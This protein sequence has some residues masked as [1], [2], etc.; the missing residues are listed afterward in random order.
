MMV[1]FTGR[2]D[3]QAY[4]N[5]MHRIAWITAACLIDRHR[6]RAVDV[7]REHLSDV[8]RA[9]ALGEPSE[10]LEFWCATARALI[11]ILRTTREVGEAAH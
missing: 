4:G 6:D 9:V 10:E 2:K 11:E 8:E 3:M 5:A 7:I 1:N